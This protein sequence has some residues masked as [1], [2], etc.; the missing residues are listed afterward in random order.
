MRYII[1]GVSKVNHNRRI[2]YFVRFISDEILDLSGVGYGIDWECTNDP[3]QATL[4]KLKTEVDEVMS[5]MFKAND[6]DYL[7]ERVI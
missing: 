4:F 3:N 1:K 2:T 7:A 6:R 5:T